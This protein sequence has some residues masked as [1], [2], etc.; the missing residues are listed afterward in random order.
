MPIKDAKFRITAEDATD[1]AFR[2]VTASLHSVERVTGMVTGALGALGL[3]FGAVQAVRFA[4]GMIDDA[5]AL[6]KLSEKTGISVE[7]LVGL[8]HAGELAGVETE[9]LTKGF[10]SLSTQMFDA[11]SG[12]LESKRN[13][14]TLGIEIKNTDGTLRS[15]EDVM[16]AVADKFARMENGTAKTALAVKLFGKA[17]MDMIP[18]LNQGSVALAQ[19]IAEGR[20]LNSTTAESAKQAEVFNDNV[21][22]LSK[23]I[24]SGFIVSMNE[25][26][27]RLAAMS[28]EFSKTA[29]EGNKFEAV[30]VAI[31]QGLGWSDPA[32][33]A[34]QK[35]LIALAERRE[36]INT[37]IERLRTRGP[38]WDGQVAILKNQLGA[39]DAQ[40]KALQA[41]INPVDKRNYD[42]RDLAV[43]GNRPA[44]TP[45][46]E[47]TGAAAAAKAAA[48]KA[49]AEK[50]RYRK[51]DLAGWVA[52]ADAVIAE[53]EDLAAQLREIDK[54]AADQRTKDL[55]LQWKQVF[56]EIDA[57]QE[58]A[59]QAGQDY[60]DALGD[61]ASKTSDTA[62]ELGLTFTSAFEDAVIG[63]KGVRDVLQGIEKDV[64]RIIARQTITEPIAKGV[65]SF[66][67][68]FDFK[69]IFG[70]LFGGGKADGGPLD[71]GKWYIAGEKG[72]EPIWGGGSG[73]F[74]AGYG[75]SGAGG[76]GSVSVS[77]SI[78]QDNRGADAGAVARL[79]TAMVRFKRE[80]V[81]QVVDAVRRG[82]ASSSFIRS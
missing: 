44:I 64:A 61:S 57:D 56:D 3:S 37:N 5:D 27:P 72:P 28:E 75:G 15:T 39:I 43:F 65:S 74:A 25:A 16:V 71:P 22:R 1:V 69:S 46:I 67:G 40:A 32:L 26:L 13:F 30:L 38:R 53:D 14:S 79:E 4:K 82:G 17:G 29:M 10:K 7:A 34:Q 18:M 59:I 9:A 76:G 33:V 80:I 66:I 50:E 36:E 24:K 52:Y 21:D 11:A 51:L 48:A 62:K 20:R 31:S 8:Q 12:L 73:A 55:A 63:G 78:N 47:D 68:G 60:L 6:S 58:R 45:N 54:A 41:K 19:I 2:K 81:P 35:E 42:A 77:F 49:L 70:N 23:S